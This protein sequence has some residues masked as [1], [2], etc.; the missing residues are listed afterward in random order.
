[1]ALSESAK[2]AAVIQQSDLIQPLTNRL[3]TC[4]LEDFPRV[5]TATSSKRNA[6]HHERSYEGRLRVI[7][8]LERR[9]QCR[10]E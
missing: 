1:M 10:I 8:L 7:R 5:Q 9:L 2:L 3:L 6:R 4:E